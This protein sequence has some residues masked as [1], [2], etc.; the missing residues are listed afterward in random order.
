MKSSDLARILELVKK[1]P[2]VLR[3]LESNLDDILPDKWGIAGGI[4]NFGY[5][6]PGVGEEILENAGIN[7]EGYKKTLG[8]LV[9]S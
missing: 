4:R 8:S 3:R 6:I 5:V 9:I 7:P 1:D 2:E